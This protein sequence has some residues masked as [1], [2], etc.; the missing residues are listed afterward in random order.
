MEE[1]DYLIGGSFVGARAETL[2]GQGGGEGFADWIA[3]EAAELLLRLFFHAGHGP[4]RFAQHEGSEFH[5]HPF[6]FVNGL[7]LSLHGI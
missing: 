1:I 2:V 4:A 5:A 6:P 3:H 7:R